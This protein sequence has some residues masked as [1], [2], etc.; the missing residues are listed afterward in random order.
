MNK[1]DTDITKCGNNFSGADSAWV[2]IF[3]GVR[4]ELC[5]RLNNSVDGRRGE[6]TS[7]T[8]RA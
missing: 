4:S 2:N 6:N 7:P 1:F 5:W 8:L 3:A